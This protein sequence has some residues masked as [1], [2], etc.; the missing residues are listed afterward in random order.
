[1]KRIHDE[2]HLAFLRTLVC[3]VPGCQDNTS[4]EAA[5]VRL[6]DRTVAKPGAGIGLKPHDFFTLP[7]CGAHHRL[8]HTMSEAEFWSELDTDPVKLALAIYAVSG[9]AQ[10]AERIIRERA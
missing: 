7:L 8:Q 1:M 4:V 3:V 5:H 6:T 2:K 9:D 10:E